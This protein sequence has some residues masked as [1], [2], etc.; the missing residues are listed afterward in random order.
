M[1]GGGTPD[2]ETAQVVGGMC[3]LITCNGSPRETGTERLGGCWE[4]SGVRG[5]VAGAAGVGGIGA[6]VVRDPVLVR[7]GETRAQGTAGHQDCRR[8]VPERARQQRPVAGV[9]RGLAAA[10]SGLAG[11]GGGRRAGAV[12]PARGG[13][14]LGGPVSDRGRPWSPSS[15]YPGRD[16]GVP[17]RQPWD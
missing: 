5:A 10:G 12:L 17:R 6:P 16:D 7:V 9:G 15:F 11:V 1:S 13:L 4:A 3:P 14:R 2:T 8:P